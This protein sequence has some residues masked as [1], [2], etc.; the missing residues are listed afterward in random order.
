MRITK[1]IQKEWPEVGSC[2]LML[3][4]TGKDREWIKYS[5]YQRPFHKRDRQ[6]IH[7]IFDNLIGYNK[8][9]KI[10]Q[11]LAEL[12]IVNKAYT[13]IRKFRGDMTLRVSP[14]VTGPGYKPYPKPIGLIGVPIGT[15][16]R[17][18]LRKYLF[19]P[20]S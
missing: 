17:G 8:C 6:N 18:Y 20:W 10:C 11:V 9:C 5:N 15:R 19:I 2:L 3:S 4:S 12:R 16:E 7:L 14:K 1:M 13:D